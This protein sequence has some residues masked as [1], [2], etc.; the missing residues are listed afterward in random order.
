MKTRRVS[1]AILLAGVSILGFFST[2]TFAGPN[3]LAIGDQAPDFELAG[4][5]DA[6]YRLADFRGKQVVVL[7]WFP[8]AFTGG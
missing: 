3:N 4:S 1:F 5:D 8:K 6:T 7:A 2:A